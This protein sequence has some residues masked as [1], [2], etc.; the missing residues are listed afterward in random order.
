MRFKTPP[1]LIRIVLTLCMMKRRFGISRRFSNVEFGHDLVLYS[2]DK[3]LNCMEQLS[4]RNKTN[5]LD[6]P[7]F[8]FYL[9][10]FHKQCLF[11]FSFFKEI[12][13]WAGP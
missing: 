12:W 8:C 9:N 10:C 13:C 6:V 7:P 4:E 5:H 2:V 3:L 1:L 11:Y